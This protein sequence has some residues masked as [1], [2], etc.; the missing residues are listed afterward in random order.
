MK[1]KMKYKIKCPMCKR[2]EVHSDK[3]NDSH[4]SY[5]CWKCKGA[6][7]VDWLTQ[8]ATPA[9]KERIE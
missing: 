6:F 3:K 5:I 1:G 9:L 7:I 4:Q 2:T 8:T